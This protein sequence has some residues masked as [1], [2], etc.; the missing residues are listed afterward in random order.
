MTLSII[1]VNYN[2][3]FFLEQCLYS[4]QRAL[5]ALEAE[6]IVVDNGSTDG[7][8]PY[9]RPKFR[10]VIFMESNS[11]CG[12]AKA[13]NTGL[14]AAKG[15]NILFLNPDT[16]LAEDTLQCC[17]TFLNT[18][19]RAG[20]LGVRMVDGSGHFLKESKRAFPAPLTS[21]FKLAGLARIF[22]HSKTFSRYH[23][24]HLDETKNHEVDVLAGAF[25][26]IRKS[27]LDKTGA[28]DETFFMYGEDVDL[29]YRIQKAGYKNYYV[30]DTA[31]I[32]FKGESTKRGSLNYVRLFYSAMS[33]FVKKWHG[34]G[35]AT[36]FIA[37]IHFAIWV[38]A[39]IAAI[40]KFIKWI[41]LPVIDA[42]FILIS[43][44]LVKELWVVTVKPGIV[45]PDKLLQLSFAAFTGIY[46]LIAYY[47]GLYD[48]A[49][50]P[51]N[52]LRATFLAT[53]VLLSLYALLPE[54]FRFSRGI[55]VF[56]ALAAFLFISLLRALL[57]KA[58]M[59]Q[60]V[61]VKTAKPYM[62]VAGSFSE[63]EEIKKL[64][65]QKNWHTK[66]IGRL[67]VDKDTTDAIA[68][69]TEVN[70]IAPALNAQE[71]IICAGR[72][73]YKNIIAFIQQKH[74]NL[75]LRFHT[76]GSCS[77]IG[78]D[79]STK[80]GE[81]IAAETNFNLARP[82]S[83]RL[84]R[85]VDVA[86]A[87]IFVFTFPIHLLLVK[88]PLRF[89]TNCFAVLYG[90]KTWIGYGAP[91]EKLPH[92]RPGVLAPNGN[93]LKTP[94]PANENFYLVDFWYAQNY[95]PLQDVKLMLKRYRQLAG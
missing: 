17:I 50:K 66:L 6:V 22:P 64:L 68:S 58:K 34:G 27:V 9:L 81:V 48:K 70:N 61:S 54:R 11:N 25:M 74:G 10:D 33:K 79:A 72:F 46:L 37:S 31:I 5:G 62:L 93:F 8:L 19:A 67:S 30:A 47:A 53:L 20:A 89:F 49:Y 36:F 7:S 78:S 14:A 91:S 35:K 56:G 41:G 45:Y 51:A 59:I 60:Q 15:E 95:E 23:L 87:L 52:V 43:F 63:Y 2:V 39:L 18:H 82:H 73:S 85:L 1:I 32:H 16:L 3:K 86:G 55:V 71:L 26:M 76:A 92:L 83:R 77:I 57:V 38:R 69:L 44:L 75:R 90:K 13:C 42:V 65:Q 88:K 94:Y 84:K 29:S 80:S 28:F 24:G 4:V 12:F 40:A 21:L